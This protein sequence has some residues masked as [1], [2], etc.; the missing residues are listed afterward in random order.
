M[1]SGKIGVSTQNLFPIIKK[2]LYSDHEIFLREIVS[3]AVD[4]TQKLKV[5]ASSGEFKGDVSGLKVRVKADK[6]AGTLTVSDSGIGMTQE[7]V[8]K[9]INQ[10]AFSGAE[11]FLEKHKDDAATIIGH[12]GLGFYSAFMV[13]D[14]V[15]IVTKSYKE[16]AQAVKWTGEGDTEYT[17]EPAERAERGTDIIMHLAE[18]EKDFLEEGKVQE[19][20]TKYGCNIKLRVGLH[21]L[22]DRIVPNLERLLALRIVNRIQ[23]CHTVNTR[24][25]SLIPVIILQCIDPVICRF[26]VFRYKNT[27]REGPGYTNRSPFEKG[28]IIIGNRVGR[29]LIKQDI[30]ITHRIADHRIH[31]ITRHDQRI[32]MVAG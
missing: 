11:E 8:E 1:T 18:D 31:R 25:V 32:N 28:R 26:K 24:F 4:A 16:G 21:I 9:Y 6:A 17:L 12:F 29:R 14:K 5:L 2:F 22:P 3:N 30:Y 20:L 7:E 27:V 13:S 15:E 23:K 19:L 10:I